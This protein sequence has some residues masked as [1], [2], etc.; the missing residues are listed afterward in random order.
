MSSQVCLNIED[1]LK[2]IYDVKKVIKLDTGGKCNEGI[3]ILCDGENENDLII[4]F[5][6]KLVDINQSEINKKIIEINNILKKKT[7]RKPFYFQHLIKSIILCGQEQSLDSEYVNVKLRW[8][9]EIKTISDMILALKGGTNYN[10]IEQDISSLRYLLPKIVLPES[11]AWKEMYLEK[12][13]KKLIKLRNIH[14]HLEV[15]KEFTIQ[16]FVFSLNNKMTPEPLSIKKIVLG[17]K[18]FISL[19]MNKIEGSPLCNS[20]PDGN[21][22]ETENETPLKSFNRPAIDKLLKYLKLLH[23]NGISHNDLNLENIFISDSDCYIIDW[24]ESTASFLGDDF[25]TQLFIRKNI[26]NKTN[27]FFEDNGLLLKL[28]ELVK[29][30]S[31]PQSAFVSKRGWVLFIEPITYLVKNLELLVKQLSKLHT[32]RSSLSNLNR[33]RDF[34]LRTVKLSS[35]NGI[36]RFKRR[37]V[38]KRHSKNK[39]R[40]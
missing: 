6:E 13:C 40:K 12:N 37:S 26:L 36:K 27:S 4:R 32:R 18:E 17:G 25:S 20:C 1:D 11:Q 22:L 14:H 29:N 23:D 31:S 19:E 21:I 28:N 33:L 30:I 38:K 16:K 9:G 8:S 2:R 7:V 35:V 39:K 10:D 3:Y 15:I 5:L 24:G 34:N